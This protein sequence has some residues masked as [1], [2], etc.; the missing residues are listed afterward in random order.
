MNK[1]IKFL[2]I[3]FAT[4]FGTGYLPLTPAT[5]GS[6]VM[7]FACF[8][9][10][11]LPLGLY[12]AVAGAIFIIGILVVPFADGYFRMKTG[13]EWDNRPIVIDEWVGQMI[14]FLPL[15]YFEKNLLNILI[16]FILFRLFDVFKFGLARWADKKKNQWGVTL[17]DCF[18]GVHAAV[19]LI[20][21]LWLFK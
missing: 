19:I 7:S 8:W 3:F 4:G 14:T 15:F 1:L 2:S 11:D 20:L 6:A 10:L 13:K 12:L 9:L 5:W 18:A 16:G 17:D 21:F